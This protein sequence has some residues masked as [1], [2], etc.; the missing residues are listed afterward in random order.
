MN[1]P[2]SLRLFQNL[3]H[4][5]SSLNEKLSALLQVLEKRCTAQLVNMNMHM[6]SC[7][8]C[9]EILRFAHARKSLHPALMLCAASITSPIQTGPVLLTTQLFCETCFPLTK[10]SG[11]TLPLVYL[12]L[13]L[14]GNRVAVGVQPVRKNSLLYFHNFFTLQFLSALNFLPFIIFPLNFLLSSSFL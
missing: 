8:R 12:S 1:A 6:K 2:S 7:F 10:G 3:F 13:A 14:Y 11:R 9:H 5:R 4:G